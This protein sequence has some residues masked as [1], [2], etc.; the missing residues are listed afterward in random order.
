MHLSRVAVG[1]SF[2]VCRL[3]EEKMSAKQTST[4]RDNEDNGA[5]KCERVSSSIEWALTQTHT[6]I[7]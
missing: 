3:R 2:D 5:K 6:I 7:G 4:K 1:Q